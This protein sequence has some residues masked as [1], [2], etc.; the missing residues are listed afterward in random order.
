LAGALALAGALILEGAGPAEAAD[1]AI[2]SCP[3]TIQT[4]GTYVLVRD[5]TCPGGGIRVE[6]NNVRLILGGHTLTGMPPGAQ[7]VLATGVAGL[8]VRGG[9]LTGFSNGIIVTGSSNVRVA[10]VTATDNN[11]DGIA[12][13]GCTGCEI[14]GSRAERNKSKGIYV[15]A[16]TG[17]RVVRNTA[18]S[19]RHDGINLAGSDSNLVADNT[20]ADNGRWGIKV[21]DGDEG[22][23]LEG[24]R[25]VGNETD[26]VDLNLPDCTNT[27]RGNTFV[28]DSEG[29]GP[30]A[31]CI[32]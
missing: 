20:A 9:T 21:S 7:G 13:A 8:S 12:M 17:V 1:V 3:Y 5:L 32:R 30:E 15:L 10:G 24:N 25:A 18:S 29:D 11:F 4:P 6:A 22:N 27:W 2:R 26:L 14:V 31:G 16:S 28:T 23:R 19:N